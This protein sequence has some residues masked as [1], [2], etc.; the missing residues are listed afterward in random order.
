MV[1]GG[2]EKFLKESGF[3]RFPALAAR[4]HVNGGAFSGNSPGMESL[5]DIKELQHGQ[6]RKGQAIDYKVK[7]PLQI[8]T[9]LK[10]M[11]LATLP[12]GSA[13]VDQ[14][15]AGGGIRSMFDVQLDIS[16][17]MEDIRDIRQRIKENF[18]VDLFLMLAQSHYGGVQP[19]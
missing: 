8:P 5:G 6:L 13:F 4:W 12:G 15:S 17:Q 1:S 19:V 10:N 3:K 9:A 11:P 2:S 18:Y 16:A 14:T 7:P